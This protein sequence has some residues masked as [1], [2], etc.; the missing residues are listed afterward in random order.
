MRKIGN[1]VSAITLLL[2]SSIID[3]N[4]QDYCVASVRLEK[5]LGWR[6]SFRDLEDERKQFRELT[7]ADPKSKNWLASW[8][9]RCSWKITNR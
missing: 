3:S 9:T 7:F 1:F 8:P 2:I 4:N 5:C 6:V